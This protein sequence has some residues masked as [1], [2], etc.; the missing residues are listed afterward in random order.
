[1]IDGI[2]TFV[3]VVVVVVPALAVVLAVP[4]R[5]VPCYAI[6]III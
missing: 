4:C 3:V 1:M 2:W 5:S 6:D